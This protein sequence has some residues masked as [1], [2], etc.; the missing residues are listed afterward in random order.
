[1]SN[2]KPVSPNKT[3]DLNKQLKSGK[4]P[5]SDGLLPQ[6]FQKYL[7]CWAAPLATLFTSTNQFGI[8]PESWTNA[9]IVLIFKK[10]D[11]KLPK[12]NWQ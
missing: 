7:E 1:M 9:I 10:G 6:L 3:E 5:G 4:A 8:L 2:W 12:D 11:P